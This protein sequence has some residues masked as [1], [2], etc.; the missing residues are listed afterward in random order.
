MQV[1]LPSYHFPREEAVSREETASSHLSLKAKIDQ[2]QLEEGRE[3]QREPM[4]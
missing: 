3:E 1:E 4:I 2:F